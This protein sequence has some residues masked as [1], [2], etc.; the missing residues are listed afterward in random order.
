MG[1]GR[2]DKSAQIFQRWFE[3]LKSQTQLEI[4]LD[5]DALWFLAKQENIHLS[6]NMYLTFRLK[7]HDY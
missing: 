3:I 1:L 5:A 2:D 4:V 6:K 7:Q